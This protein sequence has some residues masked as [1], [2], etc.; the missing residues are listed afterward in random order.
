MRAELMAHASKT[1][2]EF[3]SH[4]ES[5]ALKHKSEINNDPE[6][7]MQF[8]KMCA[9]IGV[10][11]L[12]SNKGFWAELLGSNDFYYELGVQ[13]LDVC[14]ATRESNG[15]LIAAD[16]LHRHLLRMRG[17]KAAAVSLEDISNSVQKMKVLGAG[18][19][20][21]DAGGKKMVVSVP[22]E[23][24]I[25]HSAVISLA[26]GAGGHVDAAGVRSGLGWPADRTE[27]ALAMLVREGM[28][29]VDDQAGAGARRYWFLSAL[30]E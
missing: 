27:R 15:G 5:F 20:V 16:R 11:P 21:I 24:N 12:A 2:A 4:L 6:F 10:D 19:D 22:V 13:V 26:E 30:G 8:Q 18:L 7:R 3:R 14:Q 9:S 17:A 1:V 29:W 28:V 23:L 25:D